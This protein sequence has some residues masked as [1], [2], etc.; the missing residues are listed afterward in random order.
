MAA[1]WRVQAPA[2][3]GKHHTD[4]LASGAFAGATRSPALQPLAPISTS[5][6]SYV[7]LLVQPKH[8]VCAADL[9]VLASLLFWP[10][11]GVG[12]GGGAL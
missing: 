8:P 3:T 2:G 5:K 9:H 11:G 10:S 7:G 4:A 12:L 6:M 1:H